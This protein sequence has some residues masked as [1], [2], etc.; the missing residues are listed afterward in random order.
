MINDQ[1][2]HARIEAAIAE[3]EKATSA[4]VVVVLTPASGS[5]RDT[6]LLAGSLCALLTLATVIV[7]NLEPSEFVAAG[8]TGLAFGFGALLCSRISGLRRL[9]TTEERRLD[10]VRTHALVA[11]HEE[12]VTATSQRNGLLLYVSMLEWTAEVL[13]DL[14]IDDKMPQA[15]WNGLRGEMI[16]APNARSLA[17]AVISTIGQ[18]G[19]QLAKEFPPG[20]EPVDELSNRPRIRS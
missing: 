18:C 12:G 11:F 3:A 16:A 8:L 2:F 17:D 5:Y 7:A 6:D 9:L 19:E 20:D 13:P 4:E 1:A 15:M 10:Q 14:G